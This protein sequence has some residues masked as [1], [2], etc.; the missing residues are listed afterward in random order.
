MCSSGESFNTQLRHLEK[1]EKRLEGRHSEEIDRLRA[2][3]SHELQRLQQEIDRLREQHSHELQRLQQEFTASMARQENH[4]SLN[5]SL[6]E[7]R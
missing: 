7:D 6:L 1:A 4:H 3:H 2:Q 5:K